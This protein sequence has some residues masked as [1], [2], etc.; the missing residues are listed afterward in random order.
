MESFDHVELLI[1]GGS[2]TLQML[3]EDA[4]KQMDAV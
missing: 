3:P 1:L 2:E 4:S